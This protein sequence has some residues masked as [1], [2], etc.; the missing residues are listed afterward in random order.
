MLTARKAFSGGLHSLAV[1]RKEN[2]ESTDGE[3]N[4]TD[5]IP[6]NV[7]CGSLF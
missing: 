5:K 2:E 4:K 1:A 7:L 6:L 3:L